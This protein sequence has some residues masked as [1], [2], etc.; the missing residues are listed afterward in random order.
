MKASAII[1]AAGQ[2]CRMGEG[3][4]KPF[5]MLGKVPI[6]VHTLKR[7]QTNPLIN[8]IVLVVPEDKIEYCEQKIVTGF[9]LTKVNKIISGGE[10][11][12]ESVFNGLQS[13]SQET[14]IVVVHDGVRPFLSKP[15][16]DTSIKKA[17]EKGTA[18]VAISVKDTLMKISEQVFKREIL[19]DAFEKAQKD[20]FFGT[21]ESTL[22]T[23]LGIPVY[24]VNGSELNIKITTPEDLVLGESI[25]KAFCR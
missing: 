6:I 5:L 15:I 19:I 11:R 3:K 18:I 7:F 13:I 14:D 23:R 24:V 12:Q 2:G 8:E 20:D 4:K 25:L 16:L 9:S 1:T 10:R 21:D 22:V 17:R